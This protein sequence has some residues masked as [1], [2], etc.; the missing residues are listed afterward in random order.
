MNFPFACIGEV[1]FHMLSADQLKCICDKVDNY[2]TGVRIL[3]LC[4]LYQMA[5]INV[6]D[7]Y[8]KRN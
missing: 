4:F 6:K 2:L 1:Y 8:N 7:E 5:D 3:K